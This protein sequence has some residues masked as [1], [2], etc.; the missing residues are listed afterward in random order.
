MPRARYSEMNEVAAFGLMANALDP[1]KGADGDTNA[2]F[3]RSDAEDMSK[4]ARF[5]PG[6]VTLAR[7]AGKKVEFI[8]ECGRNCWYWK[9]P[10]NT[11]IYHFDPINYQLIGKANG[12]R[13]VKTD[14]GMFFEDGAGPC[15]DCKNPNTHGGKV[16]LDPA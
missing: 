1:S 12:R 8:T 10:D 13:Q 2:S 5:I 11:R 16:T 7:R 15:P 3:P 9:L 4:G 14:S 6:E